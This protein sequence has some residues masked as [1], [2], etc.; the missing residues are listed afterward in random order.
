MTA[1]FDFS[2]ENFSLALTVFTWIAPSLFLMVSFHSPGLPLVLQM[3][4]S[5]A[6]IAWLRSG[7]FSR[8][9]GRFIIAIIKTTGDIIGLWSVS[10]STE[11][12]WNA[13]SSGSMSATRL[14]VRKSR[15]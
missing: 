3:D 2:G 10:L 6:Y 1:T 14:S 13:L 15:T 5:S 4:T 7:I 8:R 12:G 11:K 9:L